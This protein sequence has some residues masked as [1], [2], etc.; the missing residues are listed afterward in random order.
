MLYK[1]ILLTY[2]QFYSA[3]LLHLWIGKQLEICFLCDVWFVSL[4]P[5]AGE[6]DPNR[7]GGADITGAGAAPADRH[8]E[9][10]NWASACGDRRY[11]EVR[12]DTLVKLSNLLNIIMNYYNHVI[13]VRSNVFENLFCSPKH[14]HMIFQ[15]S[16]YYADLLKKQLLLLLLLLLWSILK[17][18]LLHHNFV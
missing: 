17:T 2:L 13:S 12:G 9:R 18:V 10:R 8:R 3:V 1:Y 6:W 11:T 7:A 14:G 16:F 15:K 5:P 4:P